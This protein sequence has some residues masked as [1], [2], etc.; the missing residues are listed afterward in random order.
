MKKILFL[1]IVLFSNNFS[2]DFS[3]FWKM[4]A[5]TQNAVTVSGAI[6]ANDQ[7]IVGLGINGWAGNNNAAKLYSTTGGNTVLGFWPNENEY[8]SERYAEYLVK[9]KNNGSLKVSN[10]KFEIGN[11]GGSDNLRA[12]FFYSTDDFKT[13]TR[14]GTTVS[15]LNKAMQTIEFSSLNVTAENGKSFTFRIF[16]WATNGGATSGKYANIQ[17]LEI[18][19]T[20]SGASV[21]LPSISTNA[22]TYV[23][24]TFL[25]IGGKIT[26]DG[27]ANIDSRGVCWNSTGSP[28]INNSKINL[29]NG[30][31]TF[32]T[33]IQTLQPNTTYYFRAFATNSAGTAYGN[34]I[35][36]TTLAQKTV[37]KI[38]T[39]AI[40]NILAKSA[41]SGGNI[42]DWGG[43]SIKVKGI[44]WSKNQNPTIN[45][46]FTENGSDISTFTSVM[47]NLEPSTTYYVR[48]YAINSIGIGYGNELSFTTQAVA[49]NVKKVVA[50]DG[51]GDYKTVQEAFDNV[52]DFYTGTWTIFVKKGTYKEK[53]LLSSKK[54]NVIL[55]GE[56]RDNT[57]LTYDDYSGRVVNGVTLGT[58]TSYSVAIDASD[59]IAKNITFQNTSTVAQAVA[60]RIQGDRHSFYN[61]KLLGYQDTYYTWGG[62]GVG[63]SYMKNCFIEG[64]VDFIFGR[65]IVV[66]DNCTIN[67]NRNAGT[68]TAASTDESSKFGYVFL[69]CKI[70]YN[71]IGFD[72]NPIT[73]FYLGRPWQNS[74]RTVFIKC[75]EPDAL[76]AQGWL[77]WNVTPALYAEYKCYGA[78][79]DFSKRLNISRQLTDNEAKDYNI[80]NIF[81]K[82]S[83]PSF[84]NDWLPDTT[85][86]TSIKNENDV[87]F[88]PNDFELYQNYPNPFNPE[89]VIK[90]KIPS[91]NISND[92]LFVTLKIYDVIGNDIATL[93][94]DYQ[95]PGIYNYNF[96]L[97]NHK[98]SSGVYFYQLIV[99]NISNNEYLFSSTKKFVLMK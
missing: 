2:Q 51:S 65:N 64:S 12:D 15:L 1:L 39:T 42:S 92:K 76:N 4:D 24:T 28:T 50:K 26:S 63:R 9:A 99:K 67:I 27:G 57:I 71:K 13:S 23:S 91:N 84:S 31:G 8:N 97:T 40:S 55:E 96:S 72:N 81:S 47:S 11:S 43:D 75:E 58:S 74:P 94:N 34:E 21:E 41:Q 70:T 95:T 25:T 80:K 5:T 69:N 14:I 77:T 49:P 38:T 89:T 33:K 90:Y 93:V 44:C 53:L 82:N 52:P 19:G 98:L 32:S 85:I 48:A 7:K 22:A 62:S 78:G 35:V 56:D 6:L 83:S 60:L 68:L 88:I 30:V 54:V 17:N 73:S 16:L 79:S 45:N 37:P 36:V 20:T 66:F 10:I 18:K 86:T 87:G 3:A 61:C 29:G 59:F 46:S